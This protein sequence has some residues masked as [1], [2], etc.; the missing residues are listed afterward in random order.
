MNRL[1]KARETQLR[2]M[3]LDGN[4]PHKFHTAIVDLLDEIDALRLMSAVPSAL[5]NPVDLKG[6]GGLMR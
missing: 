1:M 6:P 3:L 4:L 2:E 5:K